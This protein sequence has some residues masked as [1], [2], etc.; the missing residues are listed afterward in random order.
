MLFQRVSGVCRGFSRG[1]RD[2][3]FQGY[4][5]EIQWVSWKDFREFLGVQGLSFGLYRV[6]KVSG[7][8]QEFSMD[9]RSVPGALKGSQG[10]SRKFYNCSMGYQGISGMLH[11]V[12]GAFQRV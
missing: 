1:F 9:F 7:A 6:S 10:C 3:S 4:F 8:F 12:S 2:I 5:K 11:W